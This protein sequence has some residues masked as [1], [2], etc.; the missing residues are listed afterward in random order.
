MVSR[1]DTK[2]AK[3]REIEILWPGYQIFSRYRF[4]EGSLANRSK[5]FSPETRKTDSRKTPEAPTKLGI[6]T[7]PNGAKSFI[8]TKEIQLSPYSRFRIPEAIQEAF[9]GSYALVANPNDNNIL[10]LMPKSTLRKAV[11]VFK[12]EGRAK[13][14]SYRRF[15]ERSH[16]ADLKNGMLV[17]IP[18]R[19]Y[20]Y[21][22]SFD[23]E[24]VKKNGVKFTA[25]GSGE[26]IEIRC[27]D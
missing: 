15:L 4:R 20:K 12:I 24:K 25:L 26:L 16:H 10:W 7:A 2:T 21:L 5:D 14:S 3:S 8:G 11:K 13:S 19:L 1:Q 9:E 6:K 23:W 17:T 27:N 18:N 22:D